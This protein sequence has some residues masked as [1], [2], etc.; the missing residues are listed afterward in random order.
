[1][2][3][4]L[5]YIIGGKKLYLE[6]ILAEYDYPM[7]YTCVDDNNKR[8]L[9]MC[10]D[11]DEGEYLVAD[12]GNC[13]ILN[14]LENKIRMIEAFEKARRIYRVSSVSND[15]TQ[16]KVIDVN[17]SD[18]AKDDLPDEDAYFDL[19]ESEKSI[20][21]YIEKLRSDERRLFEYSLVYEYSINTKLKNIMKDNYVDCSFKRLYRHTEVF[22]VVEFK[23]NFNKFDDSQDSKEEFEYECCF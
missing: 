14:M 6:Q 9:A 12:T 15:V 23:M 20:Q 11:P 7:L 21:A 19:L 4:V 17:Y 8:Y 13:I 16:D 3:K 22:P 5:C 2:S 10:V 1:M 18:I